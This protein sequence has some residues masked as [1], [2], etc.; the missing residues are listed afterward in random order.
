MKKLFT[1]LFSLVATAAFAQFTAPGIQ[2]QKSLGGTA[3]DAAY[4]IQQTADGGYIVAGSA[5][6]NSGDIT[7]NHGS[8]DFWVVKLDGTGAMQWQKS[9]GGTADDAARAVQQTAD[10]GYIV[11]GYTAS[12]NGDVTGNH[13]SYDCWVVKLAPDPAAVSTTIA[14]ESFSLFPNPATTE[15]RI[16][17]SEI[18]R[19]VLLT[20]ISGKEVFRGESTT[21]IPTA[22]L[23]NG[24]YLV[25]IQT[26]KGTTTQKVLVQHP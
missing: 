25:R 26:D 12:T 13:G 9:L 15:V 7:G 18:I 2:W 20:D 3:I 1:L 22:T 24:L 21:V 4:S 17:T 14:P 11:A 19:S 16:Q 6:G 10:G 8:A 5:T 23:A